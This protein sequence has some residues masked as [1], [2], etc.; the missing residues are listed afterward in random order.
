M[1]GSESTG[2]AGGLTFVSTLFPILSLHAMPAPDDNWVVPEGLPH[3]AGFPAGTEGLRPVSLLEWFFLNGAPGFGA[4][5]GCLALLSVILYFFSPISKKPVAM[6]GSA[7]AVL[8]AVSCW[9]AP[10][11]RH[12]CQSLESQCRHNLWNIGSALEEFKEDTGAYPQSL[13]VLVPDDRFG[14]TACP[15]TGL[16]YELQSTEEGYTISCRPHPAQYSGDDLTIFG[17][18]YLSLRPGGKLLSYSS[19][20]GPGRSD[21]G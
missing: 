20:F 3:Q 21:E 10:S 14:L 4:L 13:K 7:L 12:R 15:L 19:E 6:T 2:R 9:Q 17:K 16:G 8:I 5:V 1:Q 11:S 18:S